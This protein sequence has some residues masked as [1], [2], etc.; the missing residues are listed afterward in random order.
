M[1]KN[2]DL[3][4]RNLVWHLYHTILAVELGIIMVIEILEYLRFGW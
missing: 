3:K 1:Q 2:K 4:T